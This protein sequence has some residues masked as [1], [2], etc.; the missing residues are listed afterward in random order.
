MAEIA[1]VPDGVFSEQPDANP[2]V[3]GR[4]C[5]RSA[6]MPNRN[7]STHFYSMNPSST[8]IEPTH[9]EISA[10]A[11]EIWYARNCPVGRDE[12]IWFEAERQ[13]VAERRARTTPP[14]ATT[15]RHSNQPV[16]IDE[17]E[18]EDT[19]D[20]FGEPARRSPTSVDPTR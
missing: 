13:L 2:E 6:R 17:R 14:V 19:L 7:L 8:W 3:A 15:K 20:D 12:E 18:L 9:N 16:D 1:D 11:R 5:V 10:R 4:A